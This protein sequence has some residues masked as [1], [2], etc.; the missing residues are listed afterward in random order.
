MAKTITKDMTVIMEEIRTLIAEGKHV[1]LTA[2]GNSMNPFIVHLRDQIT[3][4]PWKDSDIR[5]GAVALVKDS[6]GHYLIH[7]IIRR[8]NDTI[9][10][11]GD[12]NV[13]LKETATVDNIIGV[14][15]SVTRKG[16]VYPID[17][18]AWKTYSALWMMLT[19][20]RRLPLGV[21][22]RLNR[23]KVFDFSKKTDQGI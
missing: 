1:C 11:L 5:K 23:D 13:G 10:L 6:R 3:L 18:F 20:L 22:R 14:M 2:K 9:T 12:G 8:D 21:W 15:T 16:K 7:R 19:P 4:A 17:G